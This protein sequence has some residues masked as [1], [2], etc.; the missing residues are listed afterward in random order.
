ME[1]K[2]NVVE[3]RN[4]RSSDEVKENYQKAIEKIIEE[5]AK[6][7][8]SS[9]RVMPPQNHSTHSKKGSSFYRETLHNEIDHYENRKSV[10]ETPP[11]RRS[12]EK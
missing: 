4:E 1:K 3:R 7:D 6:L 2:S 5:D 10:H 11:T 9:F 12:A 8:K